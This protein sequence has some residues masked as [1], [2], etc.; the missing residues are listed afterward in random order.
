MELNHRGAHLSG[1]R[2]AKRGHDLPPRCPEC[3]P[4]T[5]LFFLRSSDHLCVPSLLLQVAFKDPSFPFSPPSPFPST[6]LPFLIVHCRPITRCNLTLQRRYNR[7]RAKMYTPL[8]LRFENNNYSYYPEN[9]EESSPHPPQR[10]WGW[11][12]RRFIRNVTSFRPSVLLV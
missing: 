6:R 2:A 4:K 7:N 11:G 9:R 3:L 8:C 1:A 10:G 5:L 12:V